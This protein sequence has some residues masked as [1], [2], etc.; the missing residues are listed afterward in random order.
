MTNE[1]KYKST[2]FCIKYKRMKEFYRV[3]IGSKR[4]FAN[5]SREEG[6]IFAGFRI[7]Q[8]LSNYLPKTEEILTKNSYQFI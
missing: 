8:D 7:E 2:R 3:M 6:F 1:I 4:N 5:E